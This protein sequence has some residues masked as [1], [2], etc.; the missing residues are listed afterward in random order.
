ME[1]T[2]AR[3][4]SREHS[5]AHQKEPE[6]SFQFDT[7]S[8]AFDLSNKDRVVKKGNSLAGLMWAI[9]TQ[10]SLK[11]AFPECRTLGT[12]LAASLRPCHG[13]DPDPW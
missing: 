4:T 5:F 6:N 11:Q 7:C 8:V 3:E 2:S 9:G 13:T 12:A 1:L 10:L